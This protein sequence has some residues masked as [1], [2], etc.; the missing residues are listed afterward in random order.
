MLRERR[1]RFVSPNEIG[2]VLGNRKGRRFAQNR[3]TTA[4]LLAHSDNAARKR[5]GYAMRV[6]VMGGT[7]LLGSGIVRTLAAR[8]HKVL[9]TARGTK[10]VDLPPGVD[11]TVADRR[12]PVAMR[13]VLRSFKPDAVVDGVAY[14]REDALV[15]REVFA[16]NVAHLVMISTDFV[17]K[18]S[19]QILPIS[20]TAPTRAGTSYSEGKMDCEEALLNTPGLAVTILRPP[21]IMGPGGR[22]GSGSIQGR[23]ASLIDRLRKRVPVVL[24][25]A[26][27]HLLQPL[28]VDDAGTAI[29]AILGNTRTFGKVYNVCGALPGLT[30]RYYEVIGETLDVPLQ[31][32]SIPGDLWVGARP[33]QVS[34]VR[35][36]VYDLSKINRDTG[37]RPAIGMEECVRR[38]V[39]DVINRGED[40]AYVPSDWDEELLRFLEDQNRELSRLLAPQ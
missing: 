30:R 20:E 27:T 39:H 26:G 21:H 4:L 32:R 8:G 13:H 34:F 12:D 9:A 6:L 10:P 24:V 22:L 29:D 33:D 7:G 5:K 37:W 40:A 14:A 18:P 28:H 1:C 19:Y 23:D 11:F 35:H 25:D 38:T 15:D 31:V 17:Y 2:M 36:R 16:G 3:P